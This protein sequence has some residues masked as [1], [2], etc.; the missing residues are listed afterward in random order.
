MNCLLPGGATLG[1]V[2]LMTLD[3]LKRLINNGQ[4]NLQ[5]SN[6]TI[7][8]GMLSHSSG[9]EVNYTITHG[10]DIVAALKCDEDWARSN[11]ELFQY[12]EQQNFDDEKLAEVLDSIQTEDHH[13]DWFKKA[14]YF[15]GDEHEWFFLFS[16]GK[17]QG[18]CLIYHPKK[19]AI[20][21]ANIFYVEYLAVAPW[22]RDCLVRQ[23]EFRGVG[24]I[25]LKVA[26]EYSVKKLGLIP[27]LSLHSLPQAKEYYEKLKMINIEGM[28]KGDLLYFELPQ[29][30]A[31]KLLGAA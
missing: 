16:E 26:L 24:S 1:V 7:A 14:Y 21:D 28:N 22:N 4:L 12:I 18:A 3:E 29:A 9:S 5:S 15:T 19:S 25:L 13:W 17:P 6:T 30:E 2:F 20:C 8:A 27:G 31:D 10:W 11:I 23:R